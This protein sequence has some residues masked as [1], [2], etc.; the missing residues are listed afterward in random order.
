MCQT[1]RQAAKDVEQYVSEV[2]EEVLDIVAEDP[3]EQ[4]VAKQMCGTAVKKHASEKRK[5]RGFEVAM[6]DGEQVI[7][8]RGNCAVHRGQCVLR[9]VRECQFVEEDERICRNEGV[10]DVGRGT[11]RIFVPKWNEHL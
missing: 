11:S 10:V 2:A 9:S 6:A 5:Q 7:K 1:G 4:H 8:A 3:E